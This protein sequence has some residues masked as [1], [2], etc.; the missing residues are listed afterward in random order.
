ML[1]ENLS[2]QLFSKLQKIIEVLEGEKGREKFRNYVMISKITLKTQSIGFFFNFESSLICSNA[3]F[4]INYLKFGL[5]FDICIF[6]KSVNLL[7]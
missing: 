1:L 5:K 2:R 4:S 7:I 6:R 3:I